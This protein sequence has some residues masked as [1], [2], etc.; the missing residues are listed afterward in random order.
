MKKQKIV[1]R[2]KVIR[3]K[4]PTKLDLVVTG[5]MQDY[6]HISTMDIVRRRCVL[7]CEMNSVDSEIRE[8]S[9]RVTDAKERSKQLEAT[10]TGLERVIGK[11]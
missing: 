3:A 1:H 9:V 10:M 2:S 4:K 8:L 11:R 5:T 6:A 7:A